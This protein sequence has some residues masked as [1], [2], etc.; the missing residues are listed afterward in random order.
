MGKVIAGMAMSLDGFVEDRHGSVSALYPD[1]AGLREA[2]PLK[3][4][5]RDTGAVV[6]GW[7]TY[8]M[9]PDPDA[10]AGHYEFQ[11][12]VFVVARRV[13]D[14]LPKES[15]PLTFTFVTHGVVRAIQQ[16]LAVAGTKDVMIVGGPATMNLALRA[17]LVDELHVDLVPVLLGHGLR[18]FDEGGLHQTALEC[19]QTTALPGGRMH[20]KYRLARRA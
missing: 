3:E 13:P 8:A 16:A 14:R 20:L 6:M 4:A 2:E 9:A 5:I 7:R 10:Y 11:V 15:P 1:L 18:M 19:L 17:G 12:P